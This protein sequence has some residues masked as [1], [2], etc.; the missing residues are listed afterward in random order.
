MGIATKY[1]RTILGRGN[2]VRR[3][4]EVGVYGGDGRTK[5]GVVIKGHR[6]DPYTNETVPCLNCDSGYTNL[7]M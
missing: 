1:S 5:V 2:K 3:G 7:H 6:W 4:E